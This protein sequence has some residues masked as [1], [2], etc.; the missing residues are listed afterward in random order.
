MVSGT[1]YTYPNNFRAEKILAVAKFSNATVNVDDKFVLGETNKSDE[2]LKKFPLGKVPAFESADGTCLFESDAIAFYVANQQMRGQSGLDQALVAQWMSFAQNEVLPATCTW[3]FPTL[4]IMQFNKTASERAKEDVKKAMD[5]LNKHLLTRTY[6]VGERITLADLCV[7]Y[8]MKMLFENVLDAAFRKPYGNTVRWYTTIMNQPQVV[9]VSGQPKLCEKM[10]QFDAKKFA[11]MSGKGDSAKKQKEAKKDQPKKK[12]EPK[13]E[14]T[15]ASDE[16]P[17]PKPDKDP[18]GALPAGSF[19][20][21]EFKRMFSNNKEDVS[22]AWFW[23]NF[24]HENYSIWTCE[25][26]YPEELKLTFMSNN[27]ITGMFQRLDR[28]RKHAF[29]C[30]SVFGKSNDSTI[31]G[32]WIWRGQ[33]LAFE[34]SEDLQIDYSSYKWTKL[35]SKSEE[36]KKMVKDHWTWNAVDRDGRELNDGACFK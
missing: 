10:A 21:D 28:M 1:L 26:M 18:F 23:E 31:S 36:T 32:V 2:F 24:D 11:D 7:A 8:A 6:L 5:V 15:P 27:L 14:A 17:K 13:K 16:P 4:G 3:V 22:L 33:E 25:Y 19:V 20:M 29:G 12:E 35:D 34:R 30:V 9:G